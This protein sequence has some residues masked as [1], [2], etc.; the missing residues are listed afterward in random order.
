MGE[1][2]RSASSSPTPRCPARG[3]TRSCPTSE[4]RGTRRT[5]RTTCAPTT[6]TLAA[7]LH[8]SAAV[9]VVTPSFHSW[10]GKKGRGKRALAG[11]QMGA[12]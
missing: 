3:S 1:S 5:R 9:G 7:P 4:R 6:H 2:R 10:V 12:G 8:L 11:R